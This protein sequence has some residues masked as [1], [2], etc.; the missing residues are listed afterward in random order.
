MITAI[1]ETANKDRKRQRESERDE[2]SFLRRSPSFL[3][4][5]V[6]SFTFYTCRMQLKFSDLSKLLLNRKREREG[7]KW[8]ERDGALTAA[9]EMKKVLSTVS[10][11]SG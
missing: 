4:P 1:V 2:R 5:F 9:P 11:A 8:E 7:E 3:L 10:F 6:L